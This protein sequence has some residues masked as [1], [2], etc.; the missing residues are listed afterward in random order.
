MKP[1]ICDQWEKVLSD[2][3]KVEELRKDKQFE[4]AAWEA[5][6][7]FLSGIRVILALSKELDDQDLNVKVVNA[8]GEWW[9][10]ALGGKHYTPKETIDWARGTL[11]RLSGELP[12]DTF[13]PFE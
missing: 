4:K 11:K 5:V 3:R 10:K 2:W 8:F 13:R 1:E 7:V 9:E 6:S 12:P